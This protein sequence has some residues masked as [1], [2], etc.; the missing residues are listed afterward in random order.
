MIEVSDTGIGIAPEVLPRIFDAFEQGEDA[1]TRRFGGLGLGLAISRSV[2][3]AHGGRS[4]PTARGGDRGDLHPGAGGL[5][6]PIPRCRPTRSGP[7][8]FSAGSARIL[9]VE[10][11]R[12]TLGVMDR[13]LRQR[14]HEV[15]TAESVA[16]AGGRGAG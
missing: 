4:G 14:G 9:L 6:A 13:L 16:G 8:A 3:E 15:T 11:D 2:V 12:T 1:V 5:E 7:P 10:D